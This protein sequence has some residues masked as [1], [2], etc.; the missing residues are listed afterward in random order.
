MTA[1]YQYWHCSQI[2]HFVLKHPDVGAVNAWLEDM[3]RLVI[4]YRQISGDDPVLILIEHDGT[5]SSVSMR[6]LIDRTL[7]WMQR[8]P[9][10]R[11]ARVCVLTTE[12]FI[13]NIL[14]RVMR[15]FS[16]GDKIRILPA[17]KLD[18]AEAWLLSQPA[19]QS[20]K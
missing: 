13:A 16:G 8:T 17:G 9:R 2:H 12:H 4:A 1:H 6:Y 14:D 11:R 10:K 7:D 19:V 18:E 15:V 5:H 20:S 3:T